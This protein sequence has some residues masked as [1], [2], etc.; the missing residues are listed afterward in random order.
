VSPRRCRTARG[1]VAWM[2]GCAGGRRGVSVRG[3]WARRA[4]SAPGRVGPRRWRLLGGSS[5]GR[6]GAAAWQ[7]RSA[8]CAQGEAGVGARGCAQAGGA[9]RWAGLG[10]VSGAVR[11]VWSGTVGVGW[12]RLACGLLAAFGTGR[13]RRES[14][15]VGRERKRGEEEASGGGIGVDGTRNGSGVHGCRNSRTKERWLLE[16]EESC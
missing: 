8:G 4:S 16:I 13:G 1:R 12:L 2:R 5:Q 10:A 3:S 14:E 11:R 9:A 7:R 15:P 6:V